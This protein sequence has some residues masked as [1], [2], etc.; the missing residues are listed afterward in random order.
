VRSEADIK[1]AHLKKIYLFLFKTA[2]EDNSANKHKNIN[3]KCQY[4]EKIEQF[5]PIRLKV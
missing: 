1:M 4:L 3:E 2:S 5:F